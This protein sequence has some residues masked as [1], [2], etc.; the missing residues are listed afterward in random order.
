[1]RGGTR[2]WGLPPK[3]KGTPP[4]PWSQSSSP[5]VP[6]GSRASAYCVLRPRVFFCSPTPPPY[7]SD[8]IRIGGKERELDQ[9]LVVVQPSSVPRRSVA[10]LCFVFI[11][12]FFVHQA[13]A[14]TLTGDR[15]RS[16]LASSDWLVVRHVL[17]QV[18]SL[19]DAFLVSND[20]KKQNNQGSAFPLNDRS[21]G[22]G[23][24]RTIY[25]YFFF[26]VS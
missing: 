17:Q 9:P 22:L 3:P 8:C 6:V 7:P 2:L 25:I 12:R 15:L 13:T 21:Q 4:P 23:Q 20:R 19:A 14:R 18:K 11:I 26:F 24:E 5:T 10:L 1:M 16:L